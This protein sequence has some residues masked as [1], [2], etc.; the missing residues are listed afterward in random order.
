MQRERRRGGVL[1]RDE[2]AL[3]VAREADGIAGDGFIATV[4]RQSRKLVSTWAPGE[5]SGTAPSTRISW[6]CR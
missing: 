3:D 1:D 5:R 4:C 6:R 2:I